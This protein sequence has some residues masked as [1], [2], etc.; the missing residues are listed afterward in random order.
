MARPFGAIALTAGIVVAVGVA[1]CSKH[2]ASP[3][4]N[5]PQASVPAP[6]DDKTAE[7]QA[8]MAQ[9]PEADRKIAEAQ[10]VCLVSDEPLGSMGMPYKV[11]VKERDVFLCCEGCKDAIEKDPDKFLAKLDAEK[12]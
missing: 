1:G 6:E 3:K 4:Q 5:P 9:L 8:A 11:T 10:K 12:K 7:I 2:A